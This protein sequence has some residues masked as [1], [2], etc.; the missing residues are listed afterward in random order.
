MARYFSVS[1]WIRKG[2]DIFNRNSGNV[3][4]GTM[5]PSEK[6]EVIGNFLASGTVQGVT[7]AEFD[8]LVNNLMADLLHRHSELSASD[9]NPDGIVRVS[10]GGNIA[11]GS[12]TLS[13]RESVNIFGRLRISA[14]H[15]NNANKFNIIVAEQFN[16]DA[17]NEGFI[18]VHARG[19]DGSN[20]LRWGGAAAGQNAATEHQWYTAADTTTR[21]GLLRL[22]MDSSGN[23][24]HRGKFVWRGEETG[25]PFGSMFQDNGGTVV[26]IS[27]IGVAVVI[28]GM[29]VGQTNITTFLNA[30]EIA[31]SINGRFKIDWSISFSTAGGSNQNIEGRIGVN[32]VANAQ[33]SAHRFIGTATD[34]GSMG[35]TAILNLDAV[36]RIS[37]MIENDTDTQ[38]III[39][40]ASLS[41]VMVGGS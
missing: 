6:L 28:A 12:S 41:L 30:K 8:T 25:L 23:L 16:S 33:G 37:I 31:L 35:G 38:N 32:N 10:A 20:S 24:D 21:S 27:T 15:T 26:P 14:S 29:S 39:D 19:G 17:E 4:I 18:I 1:K 36:D 11:M 40:H 9:G 3:G 7:Q 2:I 5:S 34:K 22:I 13:P